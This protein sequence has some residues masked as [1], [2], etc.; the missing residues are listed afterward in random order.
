MVQL[1]VF[2][3]KDNAEHLAQ[4]MKDKGFKASVS[5]LT[6]SSRQL[7]RVRVGPAPDRA[8][9]QELQSRLR[10]AGRPGSVVPYS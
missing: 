8:A 7:Y 9:A 3:S 2:A 6:G 4:E 1:G 10:A 5:S